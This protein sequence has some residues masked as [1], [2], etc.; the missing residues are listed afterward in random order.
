[1]VNVVSPVKKL[2]KQKSESKESK[3]G[4]LGEELRLS[5]WPNYD[6]DKF[7]T[8]LDEWPEL[9]E[10]KNGTMQETLLHR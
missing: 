7:I 1:M 9:M 5:I 6:H 4:D 10:L 3:L 8:A 2:K